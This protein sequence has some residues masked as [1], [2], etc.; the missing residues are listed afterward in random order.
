MMIGSLL[1]L[2]GSIYLVLGVVHA[3]YTLIDL[4]KPSRIVPSDPAVMTA[5]QNSH[6]RLT[7]GTNTMWRAWVGFNLSHSLG[8]VLFG[9][10]CFVVA[11]CFRVFAF[12][13]WTLLVLG[14]ISAGYLA[15]GIPNWFRVPIWGI[16][17]ATG[18]LLAAWA[19]YLL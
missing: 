10:A 4:W 9:A 14:L 18:S 3:L 7:N 17:I 1:L 13:P 5:M 8:M 2:A 6:V 12:E 11:I 15:I 16:A 19:L